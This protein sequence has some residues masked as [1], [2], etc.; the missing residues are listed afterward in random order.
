MVWPD[1]HEMQV[2][3]ND[4]A[5]K[6][7]KIAIAARF[8]T[9][10]SLSIHKQALNDKIMDARFKQIVE[11]PYMKYEIECNTIYPIIYM[12]PKNARALFLA[13]LENSGIKNALQ[14]LLIND[15]ITKIQ[16]YMIILMPIGKMTIERINSFLINI[17]RGKIRDHR[18]Q[19]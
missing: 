3:A 1:I 9:L 14:H 11:K 12:T 15:V 5:C 4:I 13:L 6:T 19:K 16:A 18:N 10:L 2:Y 7:V 8:H 17:I